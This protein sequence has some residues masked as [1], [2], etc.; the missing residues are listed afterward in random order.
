MIGQLK[1]NYIFVLNNY[2][3]VLEQRNFYL[4]QIREEGKSEDFL[5]VLDEKLIDLA[6]KVY[7]YRKEFVQKIEKEL[8][9]QHKEI[10]NNRENISIKYISECGDIEKF[11]KVLLSRR[12]LDIFKGFTSKGVHRDDFSIF[13]NDREL[14][15]FGS[16]GQHRTAVLSLKLAE[17]A[18]VK[19]E[20]DEYPILLLDDFMSEL[21]KGRI[22]NFLEKIGDIQVIITCTDK[23]NIEKNDFFVYNVR[24][25][26]IYKEDS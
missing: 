24:D 12:K 22:H 7:I 6:N 25:G 14:S 18:V 1:P 13:I 3:K 5:D 26:Y 11:K 23:F 9:F 4:R 20:I 2:R 16:Q 15:V 10:T 8:I 21:D 17:L 19:T